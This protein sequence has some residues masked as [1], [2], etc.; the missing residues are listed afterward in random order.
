MKVRVIVLAF[1]AFLT[2]LVGLST[3]STSIAQTETPSPSALRIANF[4]GPQQ[5][6]AMV[7]HYAKLMPTGAYVAA[8]APEILAEEINRSTAKYQEQWNST[9]AQSWQN[10]VP[11][12]RLDEIASIEDLSTSVKTVD[13]QTFTDVG[14]LMQKKGEPILRNALSE[15]VAA[16]LERTK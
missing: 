16:A 1:T 10:A 3:P 6:Q 11:Q 5:L 15:A 8:R 13:R 12:S 14:L 7:T 2:F 4:L 9:L